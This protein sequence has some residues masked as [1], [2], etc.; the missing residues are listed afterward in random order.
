MINIPQSQIIIIPELT[1]KESKT[2]INQWLKNIHRRVTKEQWRVVQAA[3]REKC[4]PLYLKLIFHE[5]V[6]WK[7]YQDNVQLAMNVEQCISELF[8]RLEEKHGN[9]LFRTV[10]Q[11]LSLTRYGLSESELHD[12]LSLDE[13]VRRAFILFCVI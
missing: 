3:I 9:V 13:Q 2:I 6:C 5:I 8:D 4:S 10:M 7:S 12:I 1:Y 11:L